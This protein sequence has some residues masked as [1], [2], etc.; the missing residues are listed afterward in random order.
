M[1][2]AEVEVAGTV[3]A[4]VQG[5]LDR[6]HATVKP[7]LHAADRALTDGDHAEAAR[8]LDDALAAVCAVLRDGHGGRSRPGR[9]DAAVDHAVTE[10]RRRTGGRVRVQRPGHQV[11]PSDVDAATVAL[12]AD[13][14]EEAVHNAARHRPGA[15]VAVAV[16]GAADGLRLTVATRGGQPIAP[17]APGTG[18]VRLR[19]RARQ[20][21]GELR[22]VDTPE[23][24]LLELR[25]PTGEG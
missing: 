24:H 17:G 5:V 23:G 1:L 3:D 16:T 20:V 6:L 2:Q 19:V 13:A 25:L 14:V 9:L 18:L 11:L 8:H 10:A 21:G 4:Q 15:C 7:Q 22:A 12:V